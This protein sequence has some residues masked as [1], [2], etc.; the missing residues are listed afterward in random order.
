MTSWIRPGLIVR[1]PGLHEITQRA[2]VDADAVHDAVQRER[3]QPSPGP[4]PNSITL[5]E[6]RRN[7]A[8]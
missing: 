1:L 2:R 4:D 6:A 7:L 5:K 3:V 8:E